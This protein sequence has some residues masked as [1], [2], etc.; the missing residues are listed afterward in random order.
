RRRRPLPHRGIPPPM[1]S[2]G[3]AAQ[4]A[5]L[6]EVTARKP[7]NVHR[8]HDFDD[9]TYPDFLLSA[10]AIRPALAPARPL[11]D[12]P[13]VPEPLPPT[14][15]RRR[16]REGQPRPTDSPGAHRGVSRPRH[17]APSALQQRFTRQDPRTIAENQLPA[18]AERRRAL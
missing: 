3:L 13:P 17:I 9:L 14:A 5:C 18:P 6:I 12:L 15:P 4:L 1:I 7:R 8:L 2:P 16:K 11:R 10:A